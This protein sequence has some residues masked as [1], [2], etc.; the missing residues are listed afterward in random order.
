MVPCP[1][2]GEWLGAVPRLALK[3]AVPKHKQGATFGYALFAFATLKPGLRRVGFSFGF[4][5]GVVNLE[6]PIA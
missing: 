2:I 4:R 5:W 1:L 6:S 3:L